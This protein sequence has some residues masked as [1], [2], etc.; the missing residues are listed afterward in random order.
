MLSNL[1][2]QPAISQRW[3]FLTITA[4]GLLVANSVPAFA[5][6]PNGAATET[7]DPVR[8]GDK[9]EVRWGSTWTPATVL[10]VAD[11]K[12]EVEYT[13]GGKTTKRETSFSQ[14]RFP[15]GE[16]Q[17]AMWKN[18]SGKIEVAGRYI[19]RDEKEVMIRTADGED[20]TIP[21][22]DLVLNLKMRVKATPIT[23]KEN[24]INGV[25]PVRVGDEVEVK[26][27]SD[28][29]PGVVQSIDIGQVV[30]DYK[31]NNRDSSGTFDF[32]EIR[33]PNGG[34]HWEMWKNAAGT[35]SF[36]GRYVGRD[37]TQVT[38][39][40]TDG[41]NFVMKIEELE[42]RLKRRVLSVPETAKL[43]HIDGAEPFRTGDEVQVVQSE[44]WYDGKVIEL[45][46]G[47]V[48]VE[49]NNRKYDRVET[50]L[51]SFDEIRF[52]NGEGRW[53]EW[54]S[55]NGKFK[56]I[57]RYIS[58]T[59]THVTIRK[60]DGNEITV[61]NEK[62]SGAIRKIIRKTPITGEETLIG[63]VNPIRVGDQV[64]VRLNSRWRSWGN[65][66]DAWGPGVIVES[67][68]GGV[69]VELAGEKKER[70]AFKLIDVRYPNGEGAW[71]KWT[72][73]KG[74]HEVI[75]RYIRRSSKDVTLLKE[76][77]KFAKIP[78]EMLDSRLQKIVKAIPVIVEPPTEMQFEGALR[79]ASFLNNSPDFKSFTTSVEAVD[80]V[81]ALEG[82]VGIPL[83]Y[84]NNVSEV[85]PLEIDPATFDAKEPWYALGTF[86]MSSFKELRH[87]TRLYWVCPSNQKYEEGP[88]FLPEERIVDYSAKQQ[89]L[90]N[91]VLD[92]GQPVGFRTYL[93]QPRQVDAKPEFAWQ[94][95]LEETKTKRVFDRSRRTLV[96]E[97]TEGFK[98]Q[99][100]GDN[101]LLLS[102]S[103]SVSLQD[104][105]KKKIVYTIAD[106][107]KGNFVMHPSKRF[108]AV[109]K[110]GLVALIDVETGATLATE[111]TSEGGASGV[112]FSL[113]GTKVVVIDSEIRIWDLQTNAD[114]AVHERR[115]LLQSGS[116]SVVMID[117][118][119]LKAGSR[120][121]S[122]TK[123]I[124]VWS[125]AGDGVTIRHDEM[126]GNMDL[127][128][129]Y[130]NA[131]RFSRD[132]GSQ[133]ALVGLAQVPHAPA[134]K[135]L[136]E[137]EKIEMRML[138][139]GAGVRIEAAGD[140]RVRDGVLAGIEKAG[141]HEDPNA[142]VLIKASAERG[143]TQ[144]QQFEKYEVTRFG[145]QATGEVTSVSATPWEQKV[146]IIFDGKTA[147][148]D[149]R[150]TGVPSGFDLGGGKTVNSQVQNQ[151]QA[152]YS[153]F[154]NLKL[155]KEIIYPKF[156]NGLGRTSITV[157]GFVDQ[158]YAEVP[159]V[160]EDLIE[161]GQFEGDDPAEVPEE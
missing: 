71:Q 102:S 12:A 148:S 62:F 50:E 123:E 125:Y 119:W 138:R 95:P 152:T 38:I 143:E 122:L 97:T 27:F 124:V 47:E 105:E 114:P 59:K 146:Q 107:R 53:R 20:L 128:A 42:R 16:G 157:N 147:W 34:W 101:Q 39:K 100:V 142:E 24:A 29:H 30:V 45:K 7:L 131:S 65:P 14:I 52:P 85:M 115:N 75:A 15:N 37:P 91:V 108:F 58:R 90:L 150:S 18:R 67:A 48:M 81:K 25:V 84:G 133:V 63:G 82:G 8:A 44:V 149:S 13:S 56:I 60:L 4:V 35:L 5:Q 89:R 153:L 64:E 49:Y 10:S 106:V 32:D 145:R 36:E 116:G 113:D 126:L 99:L 72:T 66:A 51:F 61:Q 3:F 22:N 121:Y 132:K 92:G 17:W 83:E 111:K 130:K 78:I 73:D 120:L 11:G 151:T 79:V 134:V 110:S 86:A 98:V 55:A 40:K 77:G 109:I 136:R 2:N 31:R 155:P 112:G 141:W 140:K 88:G 135:A 80:T 21:I 137:L 19:A 129:A 160:V 68:A 156:R 94:V 33:F 6:A 57:G 70:K 9:V 104:F 23:G 26:Y 87:W 144:T 139:P 118:K 96:N 74:G 28:W 43:N 158:L 93:V 54:A 159:E 161:T 46:D 41:S 127:L 1:I 76:N 117:D 103:G 154:E 69:M